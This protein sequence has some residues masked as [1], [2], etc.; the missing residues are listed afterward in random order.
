M[1]EHPRFCRKYDLM[2]MVKLNE[3][4]Q[5]EAE[6]RLLCKVLNFV[7]LVLHMGADQLRNGLSSIE[8]SKR[9]L[10]WDALEVRSAECNGQFLVYA[11]TRSTSS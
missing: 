1:A 8:H 9:K 6:G 5:R 2:A 7:L 3:T 11:D 4:E 10:K